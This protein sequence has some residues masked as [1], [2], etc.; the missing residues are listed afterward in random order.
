[1][2]M[3]KHQNQDN[4]GKG[5]LRVGMG[6]AKGCDYEMVV[7]KG[8]SLICDVLFLKWGVQFC[9]TIADHHLA[10]LLLTLISI[11]SYL[12]NINYFEK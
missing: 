4:S 3:N 1:M 2:V 10:L 8:L 6:T 12:Q 9:R 11:I 5:V 7:H